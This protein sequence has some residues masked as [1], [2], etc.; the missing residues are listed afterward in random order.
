MG[1]DGMMPALPTPPVIDPLD[2]GRIAVVR[3]TR[4]RALARRAAAAGAE[5][6]AT[7]AG[8]LMIRRGVSSWH[9]CDVMS[10]AS[11]LDRMVASV[12]VHAQEVLE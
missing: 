11:V 3:A 7:N 2:P 9:C 10:A 12:G 8:T 4:V 1:D 6:I 5:L